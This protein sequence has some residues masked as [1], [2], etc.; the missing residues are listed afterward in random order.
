MYSLIQMKDVA[1]KMDQS[2]LSNTG[3]IVLIAKTVGNMVH[4]AVDEYSLRNMEERRRQLLEPS[5]R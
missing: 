1:D 2:V 4:I 5:R 3:F